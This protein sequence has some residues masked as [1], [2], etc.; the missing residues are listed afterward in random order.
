M[1]LKILKHDEKMAIV[2][3]FNFKNLISVIK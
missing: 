3:F 2:H 1:S